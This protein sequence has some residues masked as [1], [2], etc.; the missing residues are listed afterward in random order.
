MSVDFSQD[1]TR[2]L[3]QQR[4]GADGVDIPA[5]RLVSLLD[6]ENIPVED[7]IFHSRPAYEL[8]EELFVSTNS[9]VAQKISAGLPEKALLR[10]HSHPN[11]RRLENFGERMNRLGHKI[12]ISSSAALQTSLFRLEDDVV[13]K[14]FNSRLHVGVA[15]L[16]G[17]QGMETVLIKGMQRAK[18]FV[19]GK[20]PAEVHAHYMYSL[21]LYTHFTSPIRRYTDI[22]VQRQLEAVLSGGTIEFTE[23]IESLAKTAEQCNVKKDSAKNAQEQSIHIELCRAVDKRR[24]E[25]AGELICE[26]IV[27]NV[28]ESAFDVLIPEYGF[29]KRVH[30]DQ[31]PLKKAEFDK[32]NRVLEL[33]W[34]KGV[35]SNVYI[36]ED[37]RP[38]GGAA[39]R[40]ANAA[41]AATAAA[42]AAKAAQEAEERQRKMMEISSL[43]LD[44]QDALFDDD[45]DDD[46]EALDTPE[47]S[48]LAPPQ[49]STRPTQS[50][51]GSPTKNSPTSIQ[52]PHR[53]R[54]D[55]KMSVTPLG[56]DRTEGGGVSN[57]DKYLHMFTLR[58]EKS[59][60]IQ[61]VREL[62]RVPVYLKTELSKSPPYAPPSKKNNMYHRPITYSSGSCLTI[63]SLNPYAL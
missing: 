5:L 1:I 8:L 17:A 42:A 50:M 19:G 22:I 34:E 29:E 58:E 57:K 52:T 9:V 10:R 35:Q 13:R 20:L 12:D 14:V 32:T 60:Y 63:R 31:L 36:P 7:N 2:K 15:I 38:K 43:P 24:Q 27:I 51:P 49:A 46:D 28:Y 18:Y 3:R 53:T 30:C 6:D 33:Y 45:S 48:T 56:N 54:S 23:D 21:P 26:A 59:D 62:S 37:E 25:Q 16:I 41:A 39:L 61:E 55:P 47:Q 4:Y 44:G 40:A 11:Q